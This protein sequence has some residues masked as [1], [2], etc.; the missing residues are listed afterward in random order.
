MDNDEIIMD[1]EFKQKFFD[2]S[3]DENSEIK[4]IKKDAVLNIQINT[5]MLRDLHKLF[6]FI[7]ADKKKSDLIKFEEEAKK[8]GR[9]QG[10]KFSEEWM[11]FSL[12]IGTMI[13]QAEENADKEGN[14]FMKKIDDDI[15]NWKF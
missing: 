10:E 4:M 1:D 6:G 8:E 14:T 15:K 3:I 9:K 7:V 11:D 13:R 2:N 5:G 12:L